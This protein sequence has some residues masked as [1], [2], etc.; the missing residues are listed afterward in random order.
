[1]KNLLAD[2]FEGWKILFANPVKKVLSR[3]VFLTTYKGDIADKAV[4]DGI[5]DFSGQGRDKYG[6]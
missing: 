5:C 3:L 2:F 1:M 6:K 4:D